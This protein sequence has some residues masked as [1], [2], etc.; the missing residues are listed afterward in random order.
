MQRLGVSLLLLLLLLAP[1]Q[2][3]TLPPTRQRPARQGWTW[4][5]EDVCPTAAPPGGAIIPFPRSGQRRR[6][7]KGFAHS[8]TVHEWQHWARTQAC[9]GPSFTLCC[10]SLISTFPQP[11]LPFFL[12]PSQSCCLSSQGT[13]FFLSWKTLFSQP[14]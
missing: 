5:I 13:C 10:H 3:H 7:E 9:L 1:L 8:R 6:E 4:K 2:P 11:S 12:S 14:T